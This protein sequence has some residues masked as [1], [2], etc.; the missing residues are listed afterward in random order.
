MCSKNYEFISEDNSQLG[1]LNQSRV[2]LLHIIERILLRICLVAREFPPE[3]A[4]IGYYVY[5]LSKKLLKR[6]HEVIVI[7]RGRPGRTTRDFVDG[8]TVF[9]VTFFPLYPFHILL[10]GLFVNKLIRQLESQLDIIHLH[11]PIVPPV[12]TSLPVITTFHSPCKRAFKKNYR[13]T[14][15][16]RSLAEKLQSMVLCSFIEFK[17]LKLSM[18]I[19]SVSSSVN[20]EMKE[21]GLTPQEITV[22]GNAVDEQFFVPRRS[23]VETNPYVLFVGILRPGKGLF[24]LIEC[25]KRVCDKRPDVRFF[26]CGGG[27]LLG[28][29]RTEVMKKR[30]EKQVIFF[31]HANRSRLVKLYQNA[32]LLVQPSY[33]EGL[34][35]VVLEA[36]SCGL[37]VVAND[38]PG[39]R[40]VISSGFNGILVSPKSPKSLADAI[41]KLLNDDNLRKEIGKAARTTVEENYSWDKITQKVIDCYQALLQQ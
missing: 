41:L 22:V 28:S 16:L 8:I 37:P 18:K 13:D 39:N 7:T 30:L 9:R 26:L 19:T 24:D 40:T 31:G 2:F 23:A 1:L 15:N 11:S 34:S 27:S 38:I 36:M 35:T 6:G 4:G 29:L 12:E 33:H 21:Y 3:G 17:I 32:T 5:Y 20:E 14:R 10:H 25:A